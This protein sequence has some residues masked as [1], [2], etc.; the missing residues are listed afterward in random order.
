MLQQSKRLSLFSHLPALPGLEV[1]SGYRINNDFPRHIHQSFIFGLIEQGSRTISLK[2]QDV[3]IAPNEIFILNPGQPHRC[4]SGSEGH[5][6]RVIRVPTHLL[7][8]IAVQ[9]AEKN[10]ATPYFEK[11]HYQQKEVVSRFKNT[12]TVIDEPDSVMHVETAVYQLLAYLLTT[13]ATL[14]PSVSAPQTQA[15]FTARVCSYI[16]MHY[17]EPISLEDLSAIACL[18]PF[19]FQREFTRMVGITPHEYLTDRRIKAARQNLQGPDSLA[20]IALA[21]GFFD[22][23]HFSKVFKKY[24]GISPGVFRRQ[25]QKMSLDSGAA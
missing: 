23:S 15:E 6:Y 11:V 18:S 12:L 16:Q 25:N 2:N 21:S 5:S 1:L 10:Q 14:P 8:K 9:V 17:A 19:H 4:F 13:L 3:K 7:L 22:Q 24:V 20:D